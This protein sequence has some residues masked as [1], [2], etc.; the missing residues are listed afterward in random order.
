[1]R[2]LRSSDATTRTAKVRSAGETSSAAA[3]LRW[4]SHASPSTL[5]IPR[6]RKSARMAEN[7]APLG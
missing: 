7:G 4:K 1:M 5:K 2:R 6:P 3:S